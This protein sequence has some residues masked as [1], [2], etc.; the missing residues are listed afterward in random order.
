[1]TRTHSSSD[2]NSP[3]EITRRRALLAVAAGAATATAVVAARSADAGDGAPRDVGSAPP[4]PGISRAAREAAR[5]H[6][7]PIDVPPGAVTA[8]ADVLLCRSWDR[9]VFLRVDDRVQ[10]LVALSESALAIA[11]AC[12]ASGRRVAVVYWGHEPD[13]DGVG[14]FAGA[15]LAVDVHDLPPTIGASP[16]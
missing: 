13:W 7:R 5:R 12:Q 6:G 14:R 8:E 11:A 3:R 4:A 15:L 2:E 9:S 16:A 1:V 10:G